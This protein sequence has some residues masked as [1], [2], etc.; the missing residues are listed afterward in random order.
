MRKGVTKP[1]REYER[2]ERLGGNRPGRNVCVSSR[3]TDDMDDK[4]DIIAEEKNTTRSK[5]LNDALETYIKKNYHKD[6]TAI[7]QRGATTWSPLKSTD[8]TNTDSTLLTIVVE[9]GADGMYIG[10]VPSLEGSH[11]S[12]KTLNE[13]LVNLQKVINGGFSSL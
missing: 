3:I 9:K 13:L 4:M 2:C 10:I 8:E 5:I 11:A 6:T 12:G 7:Q 1:K